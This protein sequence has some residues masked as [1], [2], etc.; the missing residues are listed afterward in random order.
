MLLLL[1]EGVATE[2]FTVS[3]K[4]KLCLCVFK[5][6]YF[7]KGSIKSRL[8]KIRALIL[9]LKG[10]P[11]CLSVKLL[12]NSLS[13]LHLGYS[14]LTACGYTRPQIVLLPRHCLKNYKPIVLARGMVQQLRLCTVLK[15]TGTG[16]PVLMSGSS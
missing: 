1:A 5:S 4:V 12:R 3:H 6:T 9:I 13:Y 11:W 2:L 8:L 15:R 14:E 16:F 10:R 7:L